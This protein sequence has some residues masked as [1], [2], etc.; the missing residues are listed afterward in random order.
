MNIDIHFHL[1]LAWLPVLAY[2]SIVLFYI[3]YIFAI[4][5]YRDWDTL[6]GW[7]KVN[8]FVPVLVM[9]VYDVLQ[10]LTLF[11]VLFWDWPKEGTVTQRLSRYK[12][13][14]WPDGKRKK[15]AYAICN[16]AL[17]PF[18]KEGHC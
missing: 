2:F 10:Q 11:T 13:D 1:S 18:D 6:A 5:V 12:S 9:M 16:Q 3:L 15:A 17:N 8:T 14:S 7:V 4:N